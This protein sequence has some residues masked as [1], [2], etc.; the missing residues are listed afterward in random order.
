MSWGSHLIG[1]FFDAGN[2]KKPG[3]FKR[4]VQEAF[5]LDLISFIYHF[6]PDVI[7]NT[8]FLSV[9]IVAGLRR[10]GLLE[11]PQVT[12]VTDYDAHA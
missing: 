7:V 11:C 5:L 8:H 6:S 12:V 9:E 10:R 3:W 2:T 1:Y 4:L